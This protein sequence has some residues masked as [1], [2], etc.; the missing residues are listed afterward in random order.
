M[1]SVSFGIH[2]DLYHFQGN[3]IPTKKK[4]VDKKEKKK[5]VTEKHTKTNVSEELLSPIT[6]IFMHIYIPQ[7]PITYIFMHIY[8]YLKVSNTNPTGG[9][10][11][12]VPSPELFS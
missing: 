5:K 3:S 6:Y 7:S 12:R 2:L 4:Q 11:Q 9:A 10:S 8:I 1:A